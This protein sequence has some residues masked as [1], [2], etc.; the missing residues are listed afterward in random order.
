VD[1][2]DELKNNL[3]KTA[4]SKFYLSTSLRVTVVPV[5][6]LIFTSYMFWIFIQMT[7]VYFRSNGF[8]RMEVIE[9]AFYDYL[10]SQVLSYFVYLFFAI[11]VVFFIGYLISVLLLR[12]FSNIADHSRGVLKGNLEE[13]EVDSLNSKKVFTIFTAQF[14]DFIQSAIKHKKIK[15]VHIPEK[16]LSVSGP[17]VDVVFYI[18][19]MSILFIIA[20]CT[21]VGLYMFTVDLHQSIVQLA[22]KHLG[23]GNQSVAT[24]FTAQEYILVSIQIVSTAFMFILYIIISRSFVQQVEGVSFHFLRVMR[25]IMRGNYNARVR[26]RFNDPGQESAKTF[27]H[28]LDV[29]LPN[30]QKLE[31]ESEQEKADV[32]S[33][34]PPTPPSPAATSNTENKSGGGLSITT[35]EG[36]V[37]NNL[38]KEE[39]LELISK[40]K[41]D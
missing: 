35:P 28:L 36:L 1:I 17:T 10:F 7:Y 16:Y 2:K 32:P 3:F 30:T 31:E 37:V 20:I 11:I 38:T 18:Q 9:D 6:S 41:K 4:N 14:F 21:S 27:N 5:L 13:Y 29:I 34:L 22:I 8:G 24:F 39:V 26:L 12:P 25:E 40:T 15:P 19:Y 23:S 33:E